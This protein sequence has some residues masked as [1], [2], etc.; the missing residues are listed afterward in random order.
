[1]VFLTMDRPQLLE[2]A[3]SATLADPATSEAVVVVDGN[4]PETATLLSRM[5]EADS[6]VRLTR[7]PPPGPNGLDN[8]QRG[9]DHGVAEASCEVVLAFDDDVVPQPG[10]VSGHARHHRDDPEHLVVVG[11]MPVVTPPRWPRSHAPVRLYQEAYEAHCEDYAANPDAI[12]RNLWGGNVSIRRESWLAA[13]EAGRV[14]CYHDD[15]EF[16]LLLERQGFVAVFDRGLRGDHWY[17]RTLRGMATRAE[18]SVQ[19]VATLRAAYPGALP[20][21]EPWRRRRL[22][23]LLL[24]VTRSRAGWFAVRWALISATTLAA[25]LRLSRFEDFGARALW[26]VATERAAA[27]LQTPPADEPLR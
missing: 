12:L 24:G 25:A 8:V 23:G 15:Q 1:M 5:V 21:D 18:K 26:R 17:A 16:G 7:T 9:R 3:L 19:A 11:Y 20:P 14:P 13:I 27:R 6:R 22:R 10:L 2:R 4:D